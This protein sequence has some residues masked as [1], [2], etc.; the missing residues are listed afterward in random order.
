MEN[1]NITKE[2]GFI[3]INGIH[4]YDMTKD[5]F[6]KNMIDRIK[7]LSGEGDRKKINEYISRLLP[8]LQDRRDPY[9]ELLMTILSNQ[10]RIMKR[11]DNLEK[12][13]ELVGLGCT[14]NEEKGGE[15][16]CTPF[17]M[18]IESFREKMKAIVAEMG[19]LKEVIDEKTE[20]GDLGNLLNEDELGYEP[21]FLKGEGEMGSTPIIENEP[22][23]LLG[24]N[25]IPCFYEENRHHTELYHK[26]KVI[27]YVEE[28][29]FDMEYI[30]DD[31]PLNGGGDCYILRDGLFM[32]TDGR[33]IDIFFIHKDPA[34]WDLLGEYHKDFIKNP[35][36]CEYNVKPSRFID[37]NSF[38]YDYN[39]KGGLYRTDTSLITYI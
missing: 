18:P 38:E 25:Q 21:I 22:N 30:K 12:G 34:I 1:I 17:N 3:V 29:R 7:V 31:T 37:Y 28:V 13:G 16:G 5:S 35:C 8:T 32:H 23:V 20:E 26:G 14:P 15:M 19:L 10:E 36:Y 24:V 6:K 11:L 27:G 39:S 9:K 4:R 33:T 2:G